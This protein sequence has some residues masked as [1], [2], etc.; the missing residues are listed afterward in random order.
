MMGV[1]VI[2]GLY[3]LFAGM[4]DG[5]KMLR[6]EVDEPLSELLEHQSLH[7]EPEDDA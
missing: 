3:F 6:G 5:R 7:D 4:T 2:P 1:L